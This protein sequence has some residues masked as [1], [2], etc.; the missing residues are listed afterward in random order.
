MAHAGEIALQL[1]DQFG[2]GAALK[3]LGQERAAGIE[4]VGGERARLSI[5]PTIRS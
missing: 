3:G 1:R 2:I 5:R 4:R